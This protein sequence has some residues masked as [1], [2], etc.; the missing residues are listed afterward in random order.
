[1]KASEH[2]HQRDGSWLI[3]FY[4]IRMAMNHNACVSAVKWAMA[5]STGYSWYTVK[6]L[7]GFHENYVEW[8]IC[9]VPELPQ[10]YVDEIYLLTGSALIRIA[11]N[12]TIAFT[13]RSRHIVGSSR[14]HYW[15]PDHVRTARDLKWRPTVSKYSAKKAVKSI[16]RKKK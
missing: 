3:D 9:N 14:W 6:E 1:M 16:S 5:G 12:K 7:V 10:E 4:I 2:H 11:G 15:K 13:R 8:L